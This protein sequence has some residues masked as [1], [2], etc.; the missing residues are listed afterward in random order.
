MERREGSNLRSAVSGATMSWDNLKGGLHTGV[1]GIAIILLVVMVVNK[2]HDDDEL[3]PTAWEKAPA[4]CLLE[5][6]TAVKEKCSEYLP[7]KDESGTYYQRVVVLP[8]GCE[9]YRTRYRGIYYIANT[10][11][12]LLVE[13]Q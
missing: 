5:G 7:K 8:Y 12:G 4:D 9:I 11:G 2:Y 13:P 3:K 1:T 6:S 10:C